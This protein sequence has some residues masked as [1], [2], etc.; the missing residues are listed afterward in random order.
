LEL[1]HLNSLLLCHLLCI[2]IS[3]EGTDMR[4]IAN[5]IVKLTN[6]KDKLLLGEGLGIVVIPLSHWFILHP[7]E[8]VSLPQSLLELFDLRLAR[9]EATPRTCALRQCPNLLS[10][11]MPR[12][13]YAI[14]H[15]IPATCIT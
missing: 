2:A 10:S 1:R 5:E 11:H 4:S 9:D 3:F 15:G 8:F 7:L 14:K 13:D 6:L 12:V